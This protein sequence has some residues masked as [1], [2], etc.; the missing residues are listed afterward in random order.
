[1]PGRRQ[2]GWPGVWPP[3]GREASPPRT[4]AKHQVNRRGFIRSPKLRRHVDVDVLR[5]RVVGRHRGSW[6]SQASSSVLPLTV[7]KSSCAESRAA[8]AADVRRDHISLRINL[9]PYHYSKLLE[10]RW[11][12]RDGVDDDEGGANDEGPSPEI[13]SEHFF[14]AN[15]GPPEI[16][17]EYLFHVNQRAAA[18]NSI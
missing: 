7:W 10:P 12:R 8:G 5:P 15:K 2:G 9:G 4:A 6:M 17:S 13:A 18:G 16:A 14:C 3:S 1:M 11:L